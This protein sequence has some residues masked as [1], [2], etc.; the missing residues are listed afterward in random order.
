M[1]SQK[2]KHTAAHRHDMQR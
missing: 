2:H 1:T